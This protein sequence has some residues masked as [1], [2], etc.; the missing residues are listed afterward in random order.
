ML[1]TNNKLDTALVGEQTL[2]KMDMEFLN[3]AKQG[4]KQKGNLRMRMK[5]YFLFVFC[6]SPLG[7]M[8]PRR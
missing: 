5:V 7:T 4:G 6:L 1:M 3:S 8:R 2:R